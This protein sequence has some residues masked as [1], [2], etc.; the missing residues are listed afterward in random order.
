MKYIIIGLGNF[1]SSLAEKLVIL[2]HEVIG[3]DKEISKIEDLKEKLTYSICIDCKHQSSIDTLPIKNSDFVI[4][5]I[6]EDEGA[7]LMI[8]ALVKK[9]GA[10][11]IISRSTSKI[12]TTILEAM[13]INEIVEPEDEAAEK[14][15]RRLSV[16]GI[17]D[18]FE[19]SDRY[20]VT[21]V[22]IDSKF[23]GKTIG[24]IGFNKNFNILVLTIMTKKRE[25][26]IFSFLNKSNLY[27]IS[28]VASSETVLNQGDIM[29][30]YGHNND[31]NKL[32]S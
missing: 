26:G 17:I 21:K 19:L 23:H 10:K 2:G 6:G 15:A 20:S 11:R 22:I 28:G 18:S 3:V 25:D 5:C 31:I 12:Q 1:G 9:S 8:S 32:L 4:I 7:N 13:G 29:V 27:D 16:S 24:E 14:W 30:I